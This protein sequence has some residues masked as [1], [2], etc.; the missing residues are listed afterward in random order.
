MD[1]INDECFVAFGF[2]EVPPE[3]Y[4]DFW[5]AKI[6]FI[7]SEPFIKLTKFIHGYL[8]A[9][10]HIFFT[11]DKR[12]SFWDNLGVLAQISFKDL[13]PVQPFPELGLKVTFAILLMKF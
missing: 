1:Q 9:D 4:Q 6:K 12:F 3:Y 2:I 13:I 5:I 11:K 10:T 8:K 7:N